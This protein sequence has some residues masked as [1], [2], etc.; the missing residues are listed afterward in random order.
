MNRLIIFNI[1]RLAVASTGKGDGSGNNFG[2][3][4]RNSQ[5][6]NGYYHSNYISKP[7]EL[8]MFQQEIEVELNSRRIEEVKK[9]KTP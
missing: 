6:P 9:K 2:E 4:N 8:R 1:D 3:I 5:N 7:V